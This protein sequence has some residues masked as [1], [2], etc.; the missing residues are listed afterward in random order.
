[1][2]S[3]WIGIKNSPI[4]AWDGPVIVWHVYSGVMVKQRVHAVENRFIT[5]WREVNDEAWI[6]V[7]E[8]LPTREDADAYDCVISRDVWGG[9]SMAGWR[10]F[11]IETGFAAWQHPPGPPENY[12]ELQKT[13][14]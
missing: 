4:A 9:I 2:D 6:S 7:E 11:H 14:S 1:M 12:R 8:R 13:I 10:R 3:G 5:H